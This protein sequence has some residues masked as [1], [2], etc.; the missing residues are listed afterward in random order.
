MVICWLE[1][2]I[3]EFVIYQYLK[4]LCLEEALLILFNY[5]EYAAASS[6]ESFWYILVML[7]DDFAIVLG[8]RDDV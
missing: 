8:F 7:W 5:C 3:Y 4:V 2:L 6:D 1:F